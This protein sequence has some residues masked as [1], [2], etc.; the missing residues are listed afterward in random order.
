LDTPLLAR[1]GGL[2]AVFSCD[3]HPVFGAHLLGS[4]FGSMQLALPE[5]VAGIFVYLLL[6]AYLFAI[7]FFFI[8]N[9]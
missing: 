9:T 6:Q 2:L 1:Q 4:L 7:T 5:C 3:E 8:S